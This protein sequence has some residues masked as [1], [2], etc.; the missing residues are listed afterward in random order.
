M[1]VTQERT[2][3]E[4]RALATAAYINA[5]EDAR[6]MKITRTQVRRKRSL[7]ID[8]SIKMAVQLAIA[9]DLITHP[10]LYAHTLADHYRRRV[11]EALADI[12]ARSTESPPVVG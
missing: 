12:A 5:M 11:D 6:V 3:T 7:V 1:T 2:T 8:E 9:E 10:P 4:E